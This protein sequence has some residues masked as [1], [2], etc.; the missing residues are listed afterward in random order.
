MIQPVHNRLIPTNWNSAKLESY[1]NLDHVDNNYGPIETKHK[2]IHAY[3]RRN[4]A[5]SKFPKVS[6]IG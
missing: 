4:E 3:A 6:G 5:L 2:Q 1:L